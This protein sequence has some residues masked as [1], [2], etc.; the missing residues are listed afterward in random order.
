MKESGAPLPVSIDY[1]VPKGAENEAVA[2]VIQSMAAE[3]GFDI[4]VLD[5]R[6]HY[7]SQERFP[8]AQQRLVG[9]I[10]I[11]LKDLAKG[12]D[13]NTFCIIL[14]RGHNHDEEALYHLAPDRR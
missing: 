9:D 14:T 7:V 13:A 6:E 1:M 3:A 10:G 5:D 11:R 2:Q 8:A 12:V 4:W